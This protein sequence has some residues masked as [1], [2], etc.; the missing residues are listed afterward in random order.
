M[1]ARCTPYSHFPQR[2]QKQNQNCNTD[3]CGVRERREREIAGGNLEKGSR[4]INSPGQGSRGRSPLV[5]FGTKTKTVQNE[6]AKQSSPACG[7]ARR[8]RGP[9]ECIPLVGVQGTKSPGRLTES[10]ENS[11]AKQSALCSLCGVCMCLR[12]SPNYPR[13]RTCAE[14]FFLRSWSYRTYSLGVYKKKPLTPKGGLGVC[15][16]GGWASPSSVGAAAVYQGLQPLGD[17]IPMTG[18]RLAEAY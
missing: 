8:R 17:H 1:R 10:D 18:Q 6:I 7:G 13:S 3:W 4:G 2:P 12:I 5:V 15:G 16:W 14:D 11:D 9:G